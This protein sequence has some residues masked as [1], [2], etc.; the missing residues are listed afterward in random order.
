MSVRIRNTVAALVL[1]ATAASS[2]QAQEVIT[3]GGFE[4][5]NLSG[6][7]HVGAAN[8]QPDLRYNAIASGAGAPVS[9]FGPYDSRTG[10]FFAISDQD[11]PGS[12]VLYQSFTI[13]AAATNATLSFSMFVRN[14]ADATTIG[15]GLIHTA[16]PN[17]HARVDLLFGNFADPF[18]VSGGAVVRNFY[19]GA[20]VVGGDDAP[21]LDYLFDIT[22][23]LSLAGT[24]TLRFAQVDNQSFFNQGIDDVS[25]LVSTVPEPS[26]VVL[27]A[28][29][30]AAA[31]FV[32]RRRR[33][34]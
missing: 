26:T 19:L 20:D 16:G 17:Q 21:W 4:A 6:W 14:F 33:T 29:G 11:G 25:L 24:Y 27:V 15:D 2:M 18:D 13:D 5:G 22:A 3:N 31:G 12:G 30:M 32:Q 1:A 9:G 23:D 10:G 28:F 8:G 34:A 7:T